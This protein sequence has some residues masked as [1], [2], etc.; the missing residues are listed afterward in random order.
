M[1]DKR[2]ETISAKISVDLER[3]A[4]AVA[5]ANDISLSE[6]VMECLIERVDRE[7]RYALKIN[8]ALHVNQDLL[9]R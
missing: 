3:Q 5:E 4:R 2:T 9:A 1:A 7:L 8:A 6:L